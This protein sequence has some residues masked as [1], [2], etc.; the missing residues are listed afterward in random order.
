MYLSHG[1]SKTPEYHCWQQIKARCLNPNHR[2]FPHYGGRGILIAPEWEHDFPAFLDHVELRP[3]T[4]HSLDRVN[5]A[6]GYVPGNVKWATWIEQANNRRGHATS[7]VVLRQPDATRKTN[8]KHGLIRHPEY[9]LWAAMKN[10]CVNP[11]NS[12]YADYGG[13]GIT[14]HPP[15][16][17]NFVAF[18][19]YIG[20][21]PTPQHSLDR[22]D[23]DGPYA[24]GNV[25]WATKKE[26]RANQRPYPT[27]SAHANYEHGGYGTPEYM[28]W[29]S[30][31]TRCYNEKSD[32]YCDYGGK[33]VAM[34][35]RWRESF[36]AFFGD[37]GVRATPAHTLTRLDR[38]GHYSCGTCQECKA[39]SWPANCRW[40]SKTDQ[41]RSRKSGSRS[42]KLD[43][44]KVQLI[45]QQLAEGI[46]YKRVA[47][48][49]GIGVS[50][51][52]K[53]KRFENWV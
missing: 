3:S 10:R 34:C 30:I 17:A 15:W 32:R 25:R 27:G 23:N 13:R 8:F 45:R 51:V 9:K 49:F 48:T 47:K 1:L 21:R 19:E 38:Q 53:I 18:F 31:K 5:N 46:S 40:A 20:P 2:M 52:G 16:I 28:T 12:N 44:A 37:L 29:T 39:H 42:G 7:G 4:D 41:N 36:S 6:L 50:L 24:P 35:Q 22:I 14:I 26:Q 43:V 33:G 11:A